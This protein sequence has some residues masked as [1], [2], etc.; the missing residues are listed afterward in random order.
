MRGS[1][2]VVPCGVFWALVNQRSA[3]ETLESPV[4][5]FTTFVSAPDA[6]TPS[7]EIATWRG[8]VPVFVT[9]LSQRYH[10]TLP[11]KYTL[12]VTARF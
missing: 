5:V 7:R 1:S 11:V 3:F 12:R 10:C 9:T 8:L 6:M 2:E 4:D